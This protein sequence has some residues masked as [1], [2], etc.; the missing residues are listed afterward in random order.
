MSEVVFLDTTGDT[1]HYLANQLEVENFDCG[2]VEITGK[3]NNSIKKTKRLFLCS[4]ICKTMF[5]NNIKLPVIRQLIRSNSGIIQQFNNIIW[6]KVMRP[7]ISSIRLYI[8]DE[9]GQT[10]AVGESWLQCSLRF[11]SA[12]K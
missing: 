11:I 10:I 2:V 3:I 8:T 4:D 7:N 6:I 5:V 1:T 9:Y 12:R